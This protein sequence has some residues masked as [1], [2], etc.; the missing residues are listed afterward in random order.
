MSQ[1][2]ITCVTKSAR[3]AASHHHIVEVGI[4]GEPKLLTV[5]DVYERMRQVDLFFT[6]SPSSGAIAFVHKDHCCGIDTLRS[7]P[8]AIADNNL[9]N[10]SA[11]G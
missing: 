11:C 3:T 6:V 10:L 9:D 7:A 5:A 2:E 8:D 1:Y 4:K